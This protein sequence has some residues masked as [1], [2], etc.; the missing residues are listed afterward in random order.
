MEFK[1]LCIGA[2]LVLASTVSMAEMPEFGA[3][4][5]YA[6]GGDKLATATFMDG[7][8][9][10]LYAGSGFTIGAFLT[11]PISAESDIDWKLAINYL[12]DSIDAANGE[13]SFSR[14]PIDAL[15][16]KNFEK[17]KLGGG[18][19]YHL[20]PTLDL[21]TP[22]YNE[23]TDADNALGFILEGSYMLTRDVDL[24]LRYTNIEYDFKNAPAFDGSH[25]AINLAVT[26]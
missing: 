26:F 5:G 22:S 12:N 19:T 6:S 3:Q 21:D 17:F 24:G 10:S 13:I 15:V 7:S 1:K 14:F 11:A 20:N 18:I 23:K 4:I 8:T 16:I 2:G 25:V 9:E